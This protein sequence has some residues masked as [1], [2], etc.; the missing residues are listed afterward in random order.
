MAMYQ[1]KKEGGDWVVKAQAMK[2]IVKMRRM[3]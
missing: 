2:K 3:Q 1:A